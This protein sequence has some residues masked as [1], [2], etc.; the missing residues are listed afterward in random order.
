MNGEDGQVDKLNELF[1][2]RTCLGTAGLLFAV[3][4]FGVPDNAAG[5]DKSRLAKSIQD[6]RGGAQ[7]GSLTRGSLTR[8]SL[9]R[10]TV[11]RDR[12]DTR[13]VWPGARP[14]GGWTLGVDV[15]NQSTGVRLDEVYP[16]TAAWRVGLERRDMITTVNGFQIG[17]VGRG[18]Y[19]LERELNLRA[20]ARGWVGLLVW[21]HH[22]GQLVN[23]AVQLDQ[24]NNNPWPVVR[25]RAGIRGEVVFQTRISPRNSAI[26]VVRLVDVSRPLGG[27]KAL[28]EQE[29]KYD[30]R[31]PMRFTLDVDP[32]RLEPGRRYALQTYL[33]V[34]GRRV[35]ENDP[36]QS[37]VSRNDTRAVS[38]T[39]RPVRFDR[40][41]PR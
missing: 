3:C 17:V 22:T 28:A 23:V 37:I 15:S 7:R 38:I 41:R 1:R 11:A 31:I 8:G 26:L 18:V 20:D 40:Q 36:L 19:G 24:P 30:G 25:P 2:K 12:G 10:G 39:L 35:L 32:A 13:M 34:D 14:R 6:Q 4:A 5:V 29:I 27:L 21:D 33:L 9:T 16:G